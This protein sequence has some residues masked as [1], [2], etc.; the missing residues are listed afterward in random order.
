MFW[1]DNIV[2]GI[3][4]Y[5]PERL[6]GIPGKPCCGWKGRPPLAERGYEGSEKR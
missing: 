4:G 6:P 5:G 2:A 1:R 3:P